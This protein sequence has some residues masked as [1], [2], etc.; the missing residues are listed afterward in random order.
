MTENDLNADALIDCLTE[1]ATRL[2]EI[3]ALY[4]DASQGFQAN[5]KL[6]ERSQQES[7]SLV[8]DP[9]ELDQLPFIFTR[10][11]PNDPANVVLHQ[12][13]QGNFKARNAKGGANLRLLSQYFIVLLFHLWEQ[14][15]RG[16][17]A[18]ILRLGAPD[19]LKIDIMGDIR[20][21]RNEILKHRG[22]ISNDTAKRLKLLDGFS[23]GMIIS[24]AE[25]NMEQLVRAMKAA[26]D[27]LAR[28]SAG[29][30]PKLRTLWSIR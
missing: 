17:V 28:E 21:L 26:C 24:L 11:N 19:D 25:E 12:T 7:R 27:D 8:S 16:R 22:V 29:I 3:Y 13:T 6:T 18:D 1:F 5:V 30:D 20:L 14:E 2:D 9:A 23:E 15:Y 10:G 4:L